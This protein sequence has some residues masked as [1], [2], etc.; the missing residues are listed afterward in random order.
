MSNLS[1]RQKDLL[2]QI[3]NI[4]RADR[5][6]SGQSGEARLSQLCRETGM[7]FEQGN[8]MV[9]EEMNREAA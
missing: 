6:D 7:S 1:S 5:E 9:I 2:E 8:A 4:L 3:V